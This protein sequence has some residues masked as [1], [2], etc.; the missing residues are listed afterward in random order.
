M[1]AGR[2]G[3]FMLHAATRGVPLL[4]VASSRGTDA[5]CKSK[6]NKVTYG[7]LPLALRLLLE[8]SSHANLARCGG[9]HVLARH[10]RRNVLVQQRQGQGTDTQNRG[11][12]P[13]PRCG[14]R[15]CHGLLPP[16][17]GCSCSIV[18]A[19]RVGAAQAGAFQDDRRPRKPTRGEGEGAVPTRARLHLCRWVTLGSGLRVGS[20][21]G[22]GLGS[23]SGPKPNRSPFTLP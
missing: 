5:P 2:A 16:R 17:P 23:G 19:A 18:C 3:P 1:H 8:H 20:W 13:G 15:S 14:L 10:R 21:S 9:D 12:V 6:K 11:C 22:F 7:Q 4:F